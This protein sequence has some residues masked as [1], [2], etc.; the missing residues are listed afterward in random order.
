M[1]AQRSSGNSSN[2]ELEK[3]LQQALISANFDFKVVRVDANRGVY[4]FG[5]NC[6]AIVRLGT[7]RRSAAGTDEGGKQHAQQQPQLLVSLDG[8]SFDPMP[9]FLREFT[10]MLASGRKPSPLRAP[11]RSGTA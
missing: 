7:A 8:R 10:K 11:P 5:S 9:V 4:R 1:K 3:M 2:A 6:E